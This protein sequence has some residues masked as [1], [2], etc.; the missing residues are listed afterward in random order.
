MNIYFWDMN[1]HRIKST[2]SG[3]QR[4]FSLA[5][6]PDGRTLASG[7]ADGTVLIWD[8]NP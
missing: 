1:T 4:L 5:L 3:H 7:S 2:V 8:V 6:S